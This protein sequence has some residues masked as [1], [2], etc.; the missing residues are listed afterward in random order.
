MDN[1]GTHKHPRVMAWLRRHPSVH[2]HRTPPSYSWPSLEERCCRDLATDRLRKGPL[3]S[4]T[5]LIA[6]IQMYVDNYSQNL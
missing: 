5:A 6:A 4:V 1:F 3:G 2:L